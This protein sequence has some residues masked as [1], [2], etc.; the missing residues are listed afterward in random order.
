MTRFQGFETKEGA[1]LTVKKEGGILCNKEDED[2]AVAV[3]LGGSDN[4]KYPY[5][6][7]WKEV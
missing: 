4:K 3:V 6:I 5:C 7:V 1:D 2:Y